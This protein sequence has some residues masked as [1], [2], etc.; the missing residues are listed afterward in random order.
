MRVMNSGVKL[1][2]KKKNP[3]LTEKHWLILR[4]TVSVFV[5][6][7]EQNGRNVVQKQSA[8]VCTQLCV[9]ALDHS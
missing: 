5:S 6:R 9:F 2:K 4:V 8:T 3:Y 1:L 7:K